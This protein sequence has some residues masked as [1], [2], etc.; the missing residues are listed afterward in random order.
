MITEGRRD[1]VDNYIK[2]F[3]EVLIETD[4]PKVLED[5][6]I[7]LENFIKEVKLEAEKNLVQKGDATIT[8]EQFEDCLNRCQ[9][10]S[11]METLMELHSAGYIEATSVNENGELVY[12]LTE[13]GKKFN[14]QQ[15]NNNHF[16]NF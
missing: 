11:I 8:S 7:E 2:E 3:T 12:G 14:R 6:F 1:N 10:D 4:F 13:L 5:A 16:E 9:N 15:S